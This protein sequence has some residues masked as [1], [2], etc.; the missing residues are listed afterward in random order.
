MSVSVDGHKE[1]VISLEPSRGVCAVLFV[2]CACCVCSARVVLCMV[3][4][5][6]C[7]VMC[8]VCCVVCV[9]YVVPKATDCTMHVCGVS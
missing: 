1:L 7:W 5:V 9:A 3:L 2:Q 6:L 8:A 4:C